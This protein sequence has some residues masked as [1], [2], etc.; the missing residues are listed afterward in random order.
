[1]KERNLVKRN[2]VKRDQQKNKNVSV[3]AGMKSTA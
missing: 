3:G 2:L 1:M